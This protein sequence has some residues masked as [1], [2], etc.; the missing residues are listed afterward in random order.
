MANYESFGT[1]SLL[2]YLPYIHAQFSIKGNNMW[3]SSLSIVPFVSYLCNKYLTDTYMFVDHST[4]IFTVLNYLYSKRIYNWIYIILSLYS[5]ELYNP[6]NKLI[7]SRVI[8]YILIYYYTLQRV[9]HK[10]QIL[11]IVNL[12]ISSICFIKRNPQFS[13]YRMYTII[14]HLCCASSL[15]IANISFIINYKTLLE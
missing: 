8:S 5:F 2:L 10:H 1:S 3:K 7:L 12:I 6:T 13:S 4:I 14:W 9:D 15:Y 11:G